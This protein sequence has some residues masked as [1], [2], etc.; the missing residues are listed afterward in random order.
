MGRRADAPSTPCVRAPSS[1]Y[2]EAG[3]DDLDILLTLVDCQITYRS[4]YSGRPTAGPGARSC[5]AR[6]LQSKVGRISGFRLTITS[7]STAELERGG[8][9]ER[10]HRLAVGLQATLTTAEAA[11]TRRQDAVRV[12]AGNCSISPMPS[13]RIIFR[14]APVRVIAARGTH[15]AIAA[16]SGYAT[17]A[18]M[19]MY[20]GGGNAVDAGVAAVFAAADDRIFAPRW[21][22]KHPF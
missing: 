20:Y 13:D 6:S 11:R 3:S 21:G 16:G 22:G 5:R 8:L 12:G 15:G 10:P 2:D 14:T 4:R 7:P 18:A 19:R 9:I 17:D 1:L